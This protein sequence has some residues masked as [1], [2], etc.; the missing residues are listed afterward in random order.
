MTDILFNSR[1]YSYESGLRT[2]ERT[3]E[4]A[5]KALKDEK[6]YCSA[7]LEAFRRGEI[8]DDSDRCEDEPSFETIQEYRIKEIES[9]IQHLRQAISLMVYHFW[10]KQVISWATKVPK[11]QKKLDI[12]SPHD[13]YVNYCQSNDIS[14]DEAGLHILQLTVNLIKHGQGAGK[15]GTKLWEKVW[16]KKRD[17][18]QPDT[19]SKD[20][21][22]FL[23]LSNKHLT[24]FFDTVRNSGP[25]SKSNFNPS[26]C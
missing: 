3:Y 19:L 15:W 13:A 22:D 17:M 24:E 20:A 23:Q 12:N 21:Y 9:S 4:A 2:I 25:N 8:P 1:G 6:Y 16:D 11:V 5:H 7:Q 18:F 26:P 10:E 14:V